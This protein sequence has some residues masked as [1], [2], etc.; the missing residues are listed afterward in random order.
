MKK[1]GILGACCFNSLEFTYL[2]FWMGR[3]HFYLENGNFYLFRGM[4]KVFFNKKL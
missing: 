3:D 4:P 2:T 1:L